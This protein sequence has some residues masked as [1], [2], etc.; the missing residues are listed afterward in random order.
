MN[1]RRLGPVRMMIALGA[2]VVLL[3]IICSTYD[4]AGEDSPAAILAKLIQVIPFGNGLLKIVLLPLSDTMSHYDTFSDWWKAQDISMPQHLALNAGK[5]VFSAAVLA[6]VEKFFKENMVSRRGTPNKIADVM[7]TTLFV[8]LCGYI[9]DW[10]FTW[11]DYVAVMELSGKFRETAI[12]LY[13]GLLGIGGVAITV[14]TGIVLVDALLKIMFSIFK[15]LITYMGIIGVFAYYVRTESFLLPAVICLIWFALILSLNK[16]GR[17][18][19]D[20]D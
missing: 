10:V 5:L 15:M 1:P 19:M 4:I 20:I 2:A 13:S 14:I 9:T 3:P 16:A 6:F 7:F 17:G 8:I 12:Y 11:L 18:V